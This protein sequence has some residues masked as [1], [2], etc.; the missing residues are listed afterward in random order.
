M[1]E[2][3]KKNPAYCKHTGDIKKSRAGYEELVGARPLYI[4]FVRKAIPGINRY[5]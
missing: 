4:E 3:E 5:R 2:R 1:I